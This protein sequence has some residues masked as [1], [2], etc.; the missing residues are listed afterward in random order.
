MF[1]RG[2]RGGEVGRVGGGEKPYMVL[3]WCW[4]GRQGPKIDSWRYGHKRGRRGD[5]GKGGGGVK[6]IE[7]EDSDDVVKDK[8]MRWVPCLKKRKGKW[9]MKLWKEEKAVEYKHERGSKREYVNENSG[10]I[11]WGE[12]GKRIK[13]RRG[14]R[15]KGGWGIRTKIKGETKNIEKGNKRKK[16]EQEDYK[17]AREGK[18]DKERGERTRQKETKERW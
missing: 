10:W 15:I 1:R 5:R 9:W 2:E 3:F 13:K 4:G 7:N 16:E 17:G 6:R 18:E 11:I 14:I 12:N 8:V